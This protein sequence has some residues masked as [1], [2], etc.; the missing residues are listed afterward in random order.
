[1]E[2][3][4]P[5]NLARG[6]DAIRTLYCGLNYIMNAAIVPPLYTWDSRR[7]LARTFNCDSPSN[8]AR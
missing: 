1:M 8:G 5:G 7:I 3:R 6:K 4:W 2:S